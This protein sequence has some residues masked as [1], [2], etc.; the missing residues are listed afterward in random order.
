MLVPVYRKRPPSGTSLEEEVVEGDREGILALG[1]RRRAEVLQ[2]KGPAA[3]LV[4]P[5]L[6]PADQAP[7]DLVLERGR[8]LVEVQ[9]VS[10]R[11]HTVSHALRIG[12]VF[13]A[14]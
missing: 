14:H 3:R 7:P 2:G 4:V 5:V 10:G 13:E 6:E 12:E 1:G 8:D 9:V 11:G